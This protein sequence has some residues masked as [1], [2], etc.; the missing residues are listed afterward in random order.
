MVKFLI[1][2]PPGGGKG[3]LC[4]QIVKDYGLLHVSGGD[5]LRDEVR[6][7]T[8]L[9]LKVDAIMKSGQ[10][11]PDEVMVALI[12]NRIS[13]DDA[14]KKG[15]L[16]DGFP[17]TLTQAQAIT[18]AGINFDA[19]IVLDVSD[20]V[21]MERSAGRRL[22]PTTGEIYHLVHLPPPVSIM[23]RL[24]IRPDD[25]PAKQ[26]FRIQIYKNERDALLQHFQ[27][28]A[29][30]ID[31]NQPMDDVFEVFTVEIKRRGIDLRKASKL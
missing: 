3:T 23:N 10:L 19:M 25:Q 30:H 18:K 8:P 24:V 28:I 22:D 13:Q 5:M 29:I 7:K 15:V 20:D 26:R 27:Q 31:G 1:V 17:R 4:D 16:L 6:R 14:K 12:I 9:G 11:V 21:L 2:G